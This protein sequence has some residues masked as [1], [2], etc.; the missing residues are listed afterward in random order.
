MRIRLRYLTPLLAA[1]AAA[2][3]IAVAPPASANP[4]PTTCNNKGAASHCQRAGHS[5][6][7]VSPPVRAPQPFGSGRFGFTPMNPQLLA[8]G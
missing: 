8:I 7:H 1:G 4:N 3:A 5:S 2:A 6:I